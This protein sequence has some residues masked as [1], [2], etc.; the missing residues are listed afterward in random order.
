MIALSGLRNGVIVRSQL[1]TLS[2]TAVS[3]VDTSAW[4]AIDELR[5][6][7]VSGTPDSAQQ[8]VGFGNNILLDNL[9]FTTF[10]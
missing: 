8:G 1:V 10:L 5:V 6:D 7:F 4:G 2:D 9:S 3:H